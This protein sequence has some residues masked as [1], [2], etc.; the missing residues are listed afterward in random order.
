VVRVTS[1]QHRLLSPA[2]T[3]DLPNH[4]TAAAGDNLLGARG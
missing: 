3:S 1:L 4:G 2:S